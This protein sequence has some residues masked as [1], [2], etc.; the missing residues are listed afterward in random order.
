M[1]WDP[2]LL[3]QYVWGGP[4]A[5]LFG[6]FPNSSKDIDCATEEAKTTYTLFPDNFLN[7][8]LPIFL[9]RHPALVFESWYRTEM[10]AGQ[11]DLFDKSLATY[12]TT[13]KYSRW[14]Y[15]WYT[16]QATAANKSLDTTTQGEGEAGVPIIVEAD[17]I[18]ER[19][20]VIEKICHLCGMDP[21]HVRYEWEK[22]TPNPDIPMQGALFTSYLQGIW[23]STTIDKSKTSRG[24]DMEAKRED[25]KL[26]YGGKIAAELDR[27]VEEAMPDYLYLHEKKLS[28]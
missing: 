1:I 12:Y 25:W 19:T 3:S 26:Q 16:R 11:I 4:T 13:Y 14:L 8:W 18:M 23:N 24:L 20:P 17:D 28:G 6:A 2:A 9:I 10:R 5:P 22:H 27:L 7:S 21:E 15:D